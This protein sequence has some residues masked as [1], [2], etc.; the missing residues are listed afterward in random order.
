[1]S[2]GGVS[3]RAFGGFRL[4]APIAACTLALFGCT[5]P[6]PDADL[7]NSQTGFVWEI[8]STGAI[9]G[10]ETTVLGSPR[11]I[12]TAQGGAV[13]FDGEDDGL[14][15]DAHPL[16]GAVEFTAEVIFRPDSGGDEEQRFLHLQETG[17]RD[18]ILFETRLPG[19]ETWFLDTYVKTG[20]K[21]HTL[22]AKRFRHPLGEWYHAALVVADGEM[23]HFVNGELEMSRPIEF[24]PQGP[25]RTSIGVRIN[26]VSWFKGAV[27]EACFTPRALPPGE[28]CL[29]RT[30]R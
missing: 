29:A 5:G 3:W 30:P 18:R 24:S 23:R 10:H 4:A 19:D 13:Q 22:Y 16:S 17:S 25:G 21:G 9:A 12:D 27:S 6:Q 14:V 20:G 8:D 28:F 26:A 2:R 7:A 11:T 1:M 15:V